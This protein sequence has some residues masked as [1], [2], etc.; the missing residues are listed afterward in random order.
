METELKL[1]VAQSDLVR[2]RQ[3]PLLKDLAIA[4]PQDNQQ[5]DVYYDTPKLD[6]W[7]N[8]LTLRVRAEGGK[9]VQT[10]KS[11][12]EGSAALHERC[13]WES[14]LSSSKPDPASLARQ[15]KPEHYAKLLRSPEVVD[16]LGPIFNNK[17]RRTSWNIQMPDGQMVEC[18]LDAGEIHAGSRNTAIGELEF[19]LKQ[20]DPTQLFELALALHEEIP[21]EIANDSKA[22]RGYALLTGEPPQPVK[23]SPVE[24]RKKM[25]LE[26]AFQCMGLN[27]LQQL[28]ANVPGVLKQNVE[29]LHQMRVGLR[30]LRALLDM[31][32]ELAPLPAPLSDNVEW[33]AG[34]LGSTRDWDV[35]AGSTIPEIKG[36]DL[37]ALRS[38]AENRAHVLHVH[39]LQTLHQPR[40]TQTILQLNGWF[41]GRHWRD[42]AKLPKDS[43]LAR[44]ADATMGPLLRKAQRRLQKRI[45]ALDVSDAPGRHRVR[46]A[47]KKARYAAEF[48]RDLLPAKP[49]RRYI[50]SLSGLQ[51][52]L[53][54]LNDLA[55]AE[56]LLAELEDGGTSH[57]AVYA[58]GYVTAESEV[59]S[60]HLRSSLNAM[61]H[62]KMTS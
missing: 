26:D 6:L 48:F 32:E 39:M 38:E 58:R 16:G 19:E 1:K 3:H 18:A 54:H 22:A 42:T 59:E 8:G 7:N 14:E 41:H 11:A 20:G 15:I 45:D 49:V 56:R 57:D 13:E 60:R 23:A 44:R 40:Y 50:R 5:F 30:R 55:V 9:W 29:S 37:T 53:G 4:I 2:L 47:A 24:L 25:R 10:V 62:L 51:D 52:K 17:T 33:L 46:I 28:E 43:Q 27:C 31:F 12:A 35:L 34:E 36:P 61:E 21:L